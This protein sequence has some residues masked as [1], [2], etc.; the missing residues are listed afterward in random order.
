MLQVL[1]ITGVIFLG[2]SGVDSPT[3]SWNGMLVHRGKLLNADGVRSNNQTLL[4]FVLQV[5]IEELPDVRADY[6]EIHVRC[7]RLGSLPLTKYR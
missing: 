4:L 1:N 5:P 7:P 3:A 6:R 2:L